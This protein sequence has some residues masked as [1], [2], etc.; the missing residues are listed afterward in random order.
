M[1]A[2]VLQF[3]F[4]FSTE[5]CCHKNCGITW[6]M[7]KWYAEQCRD[8]HSRWFY[9]P[10][11]HSQHYTG[12]TEV[13]L[14]REETEKVRKQKDAEIARVKEQQRWAEERA[15]QSMKRADRQERRAAAFRGVVTRTKNRVGNGVCPCCNRTFQNLMRHM[16]GKHPEYKN[17]KV[18]AK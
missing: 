13:E 1:S 16:K 10:N 18:K 4:N 12:K 17:S 7:P 15:T 5:T 6:A 2:Q 11:G 3:A 9:C 14:A 8:D